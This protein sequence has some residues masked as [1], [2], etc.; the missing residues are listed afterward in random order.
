MAYRHVKNLIV[1]FS[2]SQSVHAFFS[3]SWVKIP[4]S[5]HEKWIIMHGISSDILLLTFFSALS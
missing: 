4:D 2:T 5:L 3:V 1:M